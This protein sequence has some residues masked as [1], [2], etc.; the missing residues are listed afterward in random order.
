ML[1]A[2]FVDHNLDAIRE[3][4]VHPETVT[5]LGDAGAHVKLICDGSMPSTQIT[6]WA[7]D[8]TRGEQ[9]PIEFL[10]EKQTRRNARLYGLDDRGTLEVGMRADVNVIDFANLQVRRPETHADLPAGGVRFLQP[11][12]GYL[13]TFVSGVQTRAHDTD[14]GERP[15]RLIRRR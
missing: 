9:I 5:G 2:G 4:L 1:G 11:V 7:R 12:S 15:G 8:R 6:H 3:M 10:V 14:T 13:A